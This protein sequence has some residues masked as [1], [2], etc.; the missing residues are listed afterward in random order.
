MRIE[1]KKAKSTATSTNPRQ[2]NNIQANDSNEEKSESSHIYS[3]ATDNKITAQ[4]KYVE[5]HLN[6]MPIEMLVDCG[7]NATII[8][9]EAFNKIKFKG[10]KLASAAEKLM[11]CQWK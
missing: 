9:I 8:T 10:H 4:H 11:D 1:V 2:C 5:V 3:V 7:N 6:G